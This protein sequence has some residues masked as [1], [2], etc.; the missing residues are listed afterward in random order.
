LFSGF[1]LP[2]LLILLA[3]IIRGVAFEY[4]HQRPEISW[5]SWWDRAI[6]VGSFVP[7]LLWGVAFANIVHGV[8]IDKNM[9]FTGNLF[10]LLNPF[11]LLGGLVTLGLFITHG[12]MFLALKTDG[13]IRKRARDFS[14]R[15]GLVTAVLAVIFMAW[16]L[17][18]MGW[19]AGPLVFFL[20]AAVAL[21]GS[22]AAA[23][24]ARE[25]WAFIGTFLCIAFAVA[26][27][28]YGL[29]PNVM[30]ST[31]DAAYSLTVSNASATNYTLKV[32]TIVAVIF[33]PIALAYQAWTYWVF[34]KRVSGHHLPDAELEAVA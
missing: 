18:L 10:T 34:R 30:P 24:M 25:G 5:H 26:G 4:R 21:V 17:H 23:M 14:I 16:G 20:L 1:Y 7:A 2:L 8:P 19:P 29:F 3:L 6:V 33:T 15:S 22:I 9:E 27:L 13:D 31:T 11:G 12:A 28:F 32:M